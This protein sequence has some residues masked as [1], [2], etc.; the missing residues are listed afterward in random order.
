MTIS[1]NK[2]VLIDYTLK[3]NDGNIIDSSH[4]GQPLAYIHGIGNLIPGLETVL[5]GKA[6]GDK[7]KTIILPED[8]YGL[9]EIETDNI[10]EKF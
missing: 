7:I 3:D 6:V 8:A 2:V 10:P 5:D 1:K 9:R 4:D